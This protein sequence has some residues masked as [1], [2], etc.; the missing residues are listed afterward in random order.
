ME[1]SSETPSYAH[2]F[3]VIWGALAALNFVIA[4]VLTAILV[5]IPALESPYNP[6]GMYGNYRENATGWVYYYRTNSGSTYLIYYPAHTK[7]VALPYGRF[8][9]CVGDR[10]A[11]TRIPL[12][13]IAI[14][15]YEDRAFYLITLSSQ[16]HGAPVAGETT[17][18]IAF[19]ATRS[20]FTSFAMDIWF[21]PSLPSLVPVAT[22]NYAAEIDGAENMQVF[23]ERSTSS[24][25]A[26]LAPDDE[27]VIEYNDIRREGFRDIVLIVIGALVGLGAAM[28]LEAIRPYVEITA[29]RRSKRRG[30]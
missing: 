10:P 16:P 2:R 20:S 27:I 18:T 4:A 12:R 9:T 25:S 6:V 8:S 3:L 11:R 21:M 29:A 13:A 15:H 19:A 30:R 5:H 23:G 17:C 1:S 14:S 26:A 28:S 24:S 7:L 22:L